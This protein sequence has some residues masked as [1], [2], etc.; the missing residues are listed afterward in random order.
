MSGMISQDK[1][2]NQQAKENSPKRGQ[3]QSPEKIVLKRRFEELR[4]FFMTAEEKVFSE[5]TGGVDHE[6]NILEFLVKKKLLPRAVA[7]QILNEES[8]MIR[9]LKRQFVLEKF[10]DYVNTKVREIEP[11]LSE[12]QRRGIFSKREYRD[13][14]SMANGVECDEALHL[15]Q[16]LVKQRSR[17]RNTIKK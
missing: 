13:Y 16:E 9:K 11:I 10:F 8:G 12:G 3:E 5:R 15:I 2:Q 14:Y 4:F 17:S 1:A 6:K 7:E